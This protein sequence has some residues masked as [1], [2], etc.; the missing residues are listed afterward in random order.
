MYGNRL[1][2]L[3]KT[4]YQI[5][6]NAPLS[7]ETFI[8]KCKNG[9]IISL[10]DVFLKFKSTPKFES[11]SRNQARKSKYDV[12]VLVLEGLSKKAILQHFTKTIKF[13]KNR[14]N[15]FIMDKYISV[16]NI[17]TNNVYAMFLNKNVNDIKSLKKKSSVQKADVNLYDCKKSFSD[18]GF[19]GDIFQK[20]NYLTLLAENGHSSIFKNP[21]CH[22]QLQPNFNYSSFPYG[23]IVSFLVNSDNEY[24]SLYTGQC[25]ASFYDLLTY[26]QDFYRYNSENPK[27]SINWLTEFK[28]KS[29]GSLDRADLALTEFFIT[30]SD[31]LD[32]SFFFLLTD[33]GE[34]LNDDE[35]KVS[36]TIDDIM[37]F[38]LIS[39]PK[40]FN[41]TSQLYQSLK[42]NS[43]E[44]NISSF[45]IYATLYDIAE[46][47]D[48]KK[49]ETNNDINNNFL[50]GKSMFQSI[51]DRS[52]LNMNVD[53]QFCK[54]SYAFTP[55]QYVPEEVLR[56]FQYIF[57]KSLNNKLKELK[58]DTYCHKLSLKSNGL[59]KISYVLNDY[60]NVFWMITGTTEPG[61]GIFKAIFDDELNLFDETIKRLNPNEKQS[62]PCVS[63]NPYS[64]YCQCDKKAYLKANSKMIYGKNRS[65]KKYI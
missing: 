24:N 3:I 26:S 42:E 9:N 63:N 22:N 39:I 29:F 7:C 46:R 23:K 34:M 51:N 45:D 61:G 41:S 19:I 13:L 38:M 53:Y 16:S 32:K 36:K 6:N 2:N 64:W 31:V 25:K 21:N 27:F 11:N 55:L 4:K 60:Q 8:L 17:T 28:N 48:P 15:I 43:E 35:E 57:I 50:K 62:L 65:H 52:C 47:L 10:V 30:N 54:D 59:F 12:H 40:N 5:I 20:N 14:D 1:H 18:M 33:K 49:H 37:P 58:L 44:A 56:T